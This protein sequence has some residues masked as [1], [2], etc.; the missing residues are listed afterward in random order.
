MERETGLEPATPSLEGSCSSQ[1][2]Y[3]RSRR[4]R[5]PRHQVL[6]NDRPRAASLQ[7]PEHRLDSGSSRLV[8]SFVA[9]S[10]SGWWRGEDSN[11]RRHSQQIYS[12]PRLTASVPL[13]P[14]RRPG[15]EKKRD[16]PSLPATASAI[17]R[18]ESA[19][20]RPKGSRH[21]R[22]LLFQRVRMPRAPLPFRYVYP[23]PW[24]LGTRRRRHTLVEL[25]RGLEP[26]TC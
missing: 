5:P 26:V 11:L 21:V 7:R 3:S 1:L 4:L 12:L 16:R 23:V 6:E 22:R 10:R 13:L 24:G 17:R 9:P 25:A 20:V 15:N 18:C 2:S 14:A 8:A 19:E